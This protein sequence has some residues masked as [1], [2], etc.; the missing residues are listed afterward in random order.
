MRPLRPLFRTFLERDERRPCREQPG[1]PAACY[2]KR[3][4]EVP[5]PETPRRPFR[6]LRRSTERAADRMQASGAA[7]RSGCREGEWRSPIP[8][9]ASSR[10]I[11][12]RA[13]SPAPTNSARNDGSLAN[14]CARDIQCNA[15]I[16]LI[17][18]RLEPADEEQDPVDGPT[19]IPARTDAR[20]LGCIGRI[21]RR[22]RIRSEGRCRRCRA[23]A[24]AERGRSRSEFAVDVPATVVASR[25][26]AARPIASRE[27]LARVRSNV[28]NGLCTLYDARGGEP[29]EPE[30][31]MQTRGVVGVI[32]DRVVVPVRQQPAKLLS[33]ARRDAVASTRR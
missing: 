16:L 10:S 2:R 20:A 7:H 30:Q 6:A 24:F 33:E 19:R 22:D 25:F 23:A 12:A 14:R 18:V 21:R 5:P 15:R 26:T 11:C 8:V 13:S 31:Q 4:R 9:P 27:F 28:A 17:E 32:V 29:P 1:T 3:S